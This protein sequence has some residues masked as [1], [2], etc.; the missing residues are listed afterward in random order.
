MEHTDW[1]TVRGQFSDKISDADIAWITIN[2]A[3]SDKHARVSRLGGTAQ[4]C[5]ELAQI[6][7][8]KTL[9]NEEMV[10]ILENLTGNKYEVYDRITE[11]IIKKSR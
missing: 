10:I 8:G 7:F 11:R 5:I 2:G 6:V 1:N 4:H 9:S 3:L